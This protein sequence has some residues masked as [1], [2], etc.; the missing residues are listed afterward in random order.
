MAVQHVHRSPDA[1]LE[2]KH[3]HNHSDARPHEDHNHTRGPHERCG[4]MTLREDG[5][6]WYTA[7]PEPRSVAPRVD[8]EDVYRLLL[9][10]LQQQQQGPAW[11]ATPSGSESEPGSDSDTDTD[12]GLSVAGRGGGPEAG[13]V[14]G[15]VQGEVLLV[16][17]RRSDCTGGT[18]RGAINLPAHSFYP[19]RGVLYDLC[20]RAGVRTVIFYCA[21]SL[22]RGPRCAAWLQDYVKEVGGD[23]QCRVMSGGV[24]GWV[25][26]YGGDLM[27]G[28]DEKEWESKYT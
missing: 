7:F 21:S 3:G 9:L 28:F 12:S 1:H 6:P 23:L 22:G 2:R 24:R 25:Q 10:Q 20:V 16:D 15:G 27:D 8:P 13:V 19:T 26:A 4:R 5:T 14:G 18:I 11:E 17:A